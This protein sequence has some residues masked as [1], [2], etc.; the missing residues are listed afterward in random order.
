MQWKWLFDSPYT[1]YICVPLLQQGVTALYVACKHGHANTVNLLLEKN[2]NINKVQHQL[3]YCDVMCSA[4]R[5]TTCHHHSCILILQGTLPPVYGTSEGGHLAIVE[6]LV[7]RG[8]RIDQPC[9]VRLSICV[10][11]N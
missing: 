4:A 9:D 8:A 7:S 6:L 1:L 10:Y 11:T 2:A 5:P 3:I